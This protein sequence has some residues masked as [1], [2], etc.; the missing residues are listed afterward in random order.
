MHAGDPAAVHRALDGL[1]LPPVDLIAA[2]RYLSGGT[3][4]MAAWA[5]WSVDRGDVATL[6]DAAL[7]SCDAR[8]ALIGDA[9][10]ALGPMALARI[11]VARVLGHHGRLADLRADLD[12][13]VAFGIEVIDA[14]DLLRW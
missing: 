12:E 5:A 8:L 7:A 6:L 4:W 9:T 2:P 11:A 13:L 3:L 14:S 1:V 10:A